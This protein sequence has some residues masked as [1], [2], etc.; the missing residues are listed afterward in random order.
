MKFWD[1]SWRTEL[2]E[3]NYNCYE[4]L[5]ECRNTLADIKIMAKLMFKYNNELFTAEE[6][7]DR[8]ADWVCDWNNQFYLFD[9]IGEN[10]DDIIKGIKRG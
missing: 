7:L 3:K 5:C 9:K 1:D 10:Y 6:C 4:R 2:E 8:T